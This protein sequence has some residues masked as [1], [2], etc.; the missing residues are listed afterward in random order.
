MFFEEQVPSSISICLNNSNI[1][2]ILIILVII[3]LNI[4]RYRY[5]IQ[6][7]LLLLFNRSLVSITL[8]LNIILIL[9][10]T[11]IYNIDLN[12]RSR[13]H[14]L[15]SYFIYYNRIPST[16]RYNEWCW[17]IFGGQYILSACRTI[18][19]I[20]LVSNPFHNTL[21]MKY[22]F[23]SCLSN[24]WIRFIFFKTYHTICLIS[25]VIYVLIYKSWQFFLNFI[26]IF[27]VLLLTSIL[28]PTLKSGLS[29]PQIATPTDIAFYS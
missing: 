2:W 26:H 12:I 22:M 18:W 15:L 23:A 29:F 25:F 8:L 3:A 28:D 5:H 19:F 11:I 1:R 9:L 14:K 4:F 6:L 10:W 17:F 16:I 21:I 20:Y 24:Y 7:V 27:N 13:N